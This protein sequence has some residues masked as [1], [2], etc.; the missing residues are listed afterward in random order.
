MPAGLN[1][2]AP[3]T[4]RL[5]QARR[6]L[7]AHLATLAHLATVA[8][9]LVSAVGRSGFKAA[10]A[11][12]GPMA[13]IGVFEK[14]L[15][16]HAKVSWALRLIAALRAKLTSDLQRIEQGESLDIVLAA[17]RPDD[18]DPT[19]AGP[20]VK[21][22]TDPAPQAE[23]PENLRPERERRETESFG[24]LLGRGADDEFAEIL[25]RPIEAVIALIREA[26]GV[27]EAEVERPA[28]ELRSRPAETAPDTPPHRRRSASSP[29]PRA[30]EVDRRRRDGGGVLHVPCAPSVTALARRATFPACGEG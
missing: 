14:A 21:A 2:A 9:G 5:D 13:A 8:V 26:L 29:P 23:R 25:K 28:G 10:C 7:R 18:A 1:S 11:D 15:H 19:E 27:D 24:R 12:A 4:S 16:R 6:M 22:E 3:P 30:G 17:E 20:K